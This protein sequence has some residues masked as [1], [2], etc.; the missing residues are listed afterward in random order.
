MTGVKSMSRV[1][2]EVRELNVN[3]GQ[4]VESD[5]QVSIN[6][7]TDIHV[8]SVVDISSIDICSGYQ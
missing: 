1:D 2:E 3:E 4:A 6:G 5:E 8:I 7:T